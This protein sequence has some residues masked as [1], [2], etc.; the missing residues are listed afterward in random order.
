MENDF[1]IFA[2]AAAAFGATLQQPKR[3]HFKMNVPVT[4]PAILRSDT[5]L[6][7]TNVSELVGT[8]PISKFVPGKTVGRFHVRHGRY[9]MQILQVISGG[10][11]VIRV[12]SID[13]K[14]KLAKAGV[15]QGVHVSSKVLT[16]FIADKAMRGNAHQA[17]A[18]EKIALVE[19]LR[20]KLGINEL[21]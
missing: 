3:E 7:P 18:R 20:D 11:M 15:T 8:I 6:Q 10:K 5:N 19:F 21:S 16:D 12:E 1:H 13:P 4:G 17:G 2:S 14:H 9:G